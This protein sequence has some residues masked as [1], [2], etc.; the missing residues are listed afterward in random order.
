MSWIFDVCVQCTSS[1]K[2][3]LSPKAESALP[4]VA[5]PAIHHQA[6]EH[7]MPRSSTF[8]GDD[9]GFSAHNRNASYCYE[10]N[11]HELPKYDIRCNQ[12]DRVCSGISGSQLEIIAQQV[13]LVQQ[14]DPPEG[15]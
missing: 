1:H 2:E 15:S 3:R 10:Y 4:A 7:V 9:F 6:L 14:Q 12:R 5:T 13:H 8:W 11:G